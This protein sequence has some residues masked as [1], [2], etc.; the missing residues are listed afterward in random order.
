MSIH[1]V[2]PARISN[3]ITARM[4]ARRARER[5]KTELAALGSDQTERLLH[6]AG[7]SVND[8][9]GIVRN[10]PDNGRLLE[11]MLA[12]LGFDCHAMSRREPET[13]RDL[14]MACNACGDRSRCA[15]ELERGT[16]DESYREFC[17]NA[18]TFDVIRAVRPGGFP[19]AA[20]GLP[21]EPREQ[22]IQLENADQTRP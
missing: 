4:E 12:A 2:L 10:H 3:W 16:A 20:N 8:L 17:P 6:D 15:R 9:P 22:Q 11:R 13:L 14:A 18:Q 7:L 1:T 5:L 21:I 19:S